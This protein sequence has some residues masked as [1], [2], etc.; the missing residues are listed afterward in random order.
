[1]QC[2]N[3]ILNKVPTAKSKPSKAAFRREFENGV[4]LL[5]DKVDKKAE[6]WM[7]EVC[8]L[9]DRTESQRATSGAPAKRQRKG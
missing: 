4:K 6:E 8:P 2:V 9:A 7:T 3:V 5:E 1:M